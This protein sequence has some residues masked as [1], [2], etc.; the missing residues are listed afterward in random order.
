MKRMIPVLVILLAAA[1]AVA[2]TDNDPAVAADSG[3][4]VDS[5]TPEPALPNTALGY[6]I[7]GIRIEAQA[8]IDDLRGK[9]AATLPGSTEARE[10]NELIATVKTNME[11]AIIEAVIEDAVASGDEARRDEAEAA[12]DRLRHPERYLT[13]AVPTDRPAP[14]R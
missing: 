5:A 10:L 11:I 4:A 8:E 2:A 14:N 7:E 12:L 6:A 1:T 3:P 13:P 9:L